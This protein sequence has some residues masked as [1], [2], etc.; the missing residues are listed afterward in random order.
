MLFGA[1]AAVKGQSNREE[2]K[3]YISIVVSVVCLAAIYERAWEA[4]RKAMLSM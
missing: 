1:R 4:V 3:L 2:S